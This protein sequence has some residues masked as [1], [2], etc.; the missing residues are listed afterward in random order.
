MRNKCVHEKSRCDLH[1][2]KDC[3]YNNTQGQ[4]V[5]EDEE[6]CLQEYKEK[7]LIPQ[8]ANFECNSTIHNSNSSAILSTVYNRTTGWEFDV[9]VIGFGTMV[10]M[11]GTRCDGNVDC[12]K[13]LD[14]ADCGFSTFQSLFVG[15]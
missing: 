6:N 5:A 4:M 14:E 9:T 10:R 11:W 15:M 2:H 3:I 8:T 7:S 12:W 1:P 13:S